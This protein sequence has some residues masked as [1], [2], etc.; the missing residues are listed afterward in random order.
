[1]VDTRPEN[2]KWAIT[3]AMSLDE[4]NQLLHEL[5]IRQTNLEIQNQEL[6]R[7][8][9]ALRAQ[10]QKG[11]PAEGDLWADIERQKQSES[12][13]SPDKGLLRCI[14]DT[15][16]D[17]IYVK[18]IDGV[19]RGCNKASERFVGLKESEQIGKTDFFFFERDLAKAIRDADRHI[20][21][22]GQENCAEEWVPLP[23]GKRMLLETKKAP[24]YKSNGEVAGIVGISRDI[25]ARKQG[26]DALKKAN[27][28]L[29]A[30]VHTV[31]HDLRTPLAPIIGYAEFLLENYQE[32]LDER[33]LECLAEIMSAGEKMLILIEDLL[34]LATVGQVESPAENLG[35]GDVARSVVCDLAKQLSLAEVSV[36]I[37]DL[38][39][40]LVPRTLLVQVF[41]NLI[42]NA[43]KYGCKTGDV[44]EVG[45]ERRGE[46]VRLYVRDHGLGIPAEERNRIFGVFYR[47]TTGKNKQGTGIGLAMVQRIACLLDGQA[48]VEETPGGGSTFWVDIAVVSVSGPVK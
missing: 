20:L 41:N 4:A 27:R 6:K 19:Y 44:I 47:G 22:S 21:T 26:E 11:A 37:G 45:G 5:R 24:F 8:L 9:E 36:Q 13:L 46:R 35:V 34:S 25:T 29:D 32:K 33:A 10:N 12:D 2:E 39:S 14:I 42:E 38:P 43:A 30:F 17:L 15:I 7:E 18:D 48:W 3:E 28:E 23:G 40:M 1:M 16:D 31:S